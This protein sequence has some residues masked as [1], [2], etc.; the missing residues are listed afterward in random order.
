MANI[1]VNSLCPIYNGMPVTFKAPC[2]CTAVEGLI[3]SNCENSYAFTFKDAHNNT[4][5]GLG[6]LF[7]KGSLVKAIL[8]TENGAAYLQN[9]DTNRYLENNF[10]KKDFV[11]V[12]TIDTVWDGLAVPYTQTIQIGGVTAESVVEISLPSTATVEE[13]T[14]FLDLGL[15]D[16]GQAEGSITIRAFGTKNTIS[17]PLNVVV[18]DFGGTAFSDSVPLSFVNGTL[19]LL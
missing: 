16:G 2:D 11:T 9:A 12:A 10:C 1:K 18:R 3:V 19:T 4:L 13:V 17:I 14:A 5:T 15:Q 7:A 6:N 8:D